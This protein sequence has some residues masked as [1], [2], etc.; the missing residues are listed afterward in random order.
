MTLSRKFILGCTA[1]TVAVGAPVAVA[2]T[3]TTLKAPLTGAA[4]KPK[5]GDADGRGQATVKVT[6]RRICF[7]LSYTKINAPSDGHIH[8]GGK[9]VAG[10]VVVGLF[11]GKAKK[12]GCV[13]A[14]ADV[15]KAIA[16]N[17]SGFYVNLHNKAFP[18][19]AIRGQL[20]KG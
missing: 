15:A 2:A 5:R 20:R 18:M 11:S 13:T 9:S 19:G 14:K 16:K 6:G 7:T 3:T 10:P 1:A 4:E 12:T 17:P 8:K